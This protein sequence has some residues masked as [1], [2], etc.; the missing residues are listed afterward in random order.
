MKIFLIV[1]NRNDGF[2]TDKNKEQNNNEA[3]TFEY[4]IKNN[5]EQFIIKNED[6][7]EYKA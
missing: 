3:K 7:I 4:T 1:I 5:E 2:M 6:T